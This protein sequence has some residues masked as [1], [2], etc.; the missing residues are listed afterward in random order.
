VSQGSS[1]DWGAVRDYY[2]QGHTVRD[3]CEKFSISARAWQHAVEAQLVPP[4]P[5]L[6]LLPSEKRARIDQMFRDGYSQAM[7]AA[8]LGMSKATVAYHARRFGLPVRDDFARRYDWSQVQRAYDAGASLSECAERFGFCKASWSQAVARGDIK[9]R[10]RRLP[11]NE[12]LVRGTKRG[13]FNLKCRLIDAGL[14]EDRCER[15]GINEWQGTPLKMQLHHINGD[16]LDNRLENLEVLCANCH[17]QTPTY[18][19]RNGHRRRRPDPD[20]EAA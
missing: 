13:R 10:P 1:H 15:C 19:G 11:L 12:L 3:C 2:E 20:V 5:E 9:A 17:S 4:P 8:E 6:T 16:G 7:I 18:G 14:K